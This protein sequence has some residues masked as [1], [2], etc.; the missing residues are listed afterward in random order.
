MIKRLSILLVII[1]AVLFAGC[2]PDPSTPTDAKSF[3]TALDVQGIKISSCFDDAT[4]RNEGER[5][6]DCYTYANDI[7]TRYDVLCQRH[8]CRL[9]G[10]E[11]KKIDL[12]R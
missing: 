12:H 5:Q 6:F 7:E 8:Q 11:Q 10:S 1:P 3:L 4:K 9:L 2:Q